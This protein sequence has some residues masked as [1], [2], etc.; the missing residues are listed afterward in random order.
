MCPSWIP[1]VVKERKA[2][3]FC[4]RPATATI[5]INSVAEGFSKININHEKEA[6]FEFSAARNDATLFVGELRVVEA[7]KTVADPVLL[8][9]GYHKISIEYT[10][11]D[12]SNIGIFQKAP[13]DSEKKEISWSALFH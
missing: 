9:K 11:P 10:R 4:A 2:A 1:V 12:P 6:V 7:G 8:A 3:K 5:S 13:G